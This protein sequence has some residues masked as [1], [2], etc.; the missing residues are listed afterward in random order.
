MTQSPDEFARTVRAHLQVEVQREVRDGHAFF[1]KWYAGKLTLDQIG[2]FYQT[3]YFESCQAGR[4]LLRLLMLA[5]DR[6]VFNIIGQNVAEEL[7][8]GNI[9]NCHLEL[10]LKLAGRYGRP[11]ERVLEEGPIAPLAT[12]WGSTGL[13]YAERSFPAGLSCFTYIEAGVPSRHSQQ[14]KALVEHYGAQRSQVEFH[15]QHLSLE[16]AEASGGKNITDASVPGY[17]GDDVHVERQLAPIAK[18]A[19]TAEE[20]QLVLQAISA[21][22]DAK[23]RYYNQVNELIA[24]G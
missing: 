9:E 18:F 13:E 12:L 4:L 19:R 21:T 1:R 24:G 6:D 2:A 15:D 5:P 20:Q 3:V 8:A 14:R 23:I 22:C 11:I 7:G 10:I 17:G 16:A